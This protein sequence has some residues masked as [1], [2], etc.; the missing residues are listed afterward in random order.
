MTLLWGER[1]IVPGGD[2]GLGYRG[3]CI[4]QRPAQNVP[5]KEYTL[6]EKAH[7]SWTDSDAGRAVAR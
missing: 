3:S 7:S 6:V 1:L 4:L 5:E 2:A